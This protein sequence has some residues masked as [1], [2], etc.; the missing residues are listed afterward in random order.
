[1]TIL[2][3]IGL[4]VS[5]AMVTEGAS[6]L[7]DS[8]WNV[9]VKRKI[10]AGILGMAVAG[11]MTTMPEFTVSTMASGLKSGGLSVGNAIGS[12]IFNVLGIVGICG[13]VRP[14]RFDKSFLAD[15]GRNALIIYLVF[16]ALSLIGHSL[17]LVDGLILLLVLVGSLYYSYSKR[18]IGAPGTSSVVH[19]GKRDALLLLGGAVLL[20]SG[21][22]IMIY[23]AKDLATSLGIPEF[24]IGLSLVAVGTSIPELATGLTSVK[25]GVEEISVGNVLGANIYNVTLVLGTSAIIST[26]VSK[27]G[28]PTGGAVCWFDIPV[29]I[30]ATALFI[31][32]GRYGQINRKTAFSFIVLYGLYIA[33]TYAIG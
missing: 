22:Y 3:V 31:F 2:S 9:S 29:M 6:W 13:L 10:S 17:G 25:K 32:L 7:T 1:M 15:Y 12:T 23:S 30:L 20:G 33:A 27:K 14:L 26:L 19:S 4:L 21:A 24:I 16:Y 8:I 5:F 18:H 28:L 11:L